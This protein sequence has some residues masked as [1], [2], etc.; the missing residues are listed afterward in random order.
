[1]KTRLVEKL[2]E[3]SHMTDENK[4]CTFNKFK[5][6]FYSDRDENNLGITPLENIK[7]SAYGVQKI[8]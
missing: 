3:L 4:K 7:R 5:L 2:Y 1:M 8:L 6:D